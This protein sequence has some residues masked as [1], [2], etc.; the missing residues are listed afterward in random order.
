[1]RWRQFVSGI[2]RE[3]I[4]RDDWPTEAIVESMAYAHYEPLLCAVHIKLY[5][6][7]IHGVRLPGVESERAER[8]LRSAEAHDDLIKL[9]SIG[10]EP[11]TEDFVPLDQFVASFLKSLGV[12]VS[13]K[14][15]NERVAP[16]A[17]S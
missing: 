17:A 12:Q 4:V 8:V 7:L 10:N 5:G 2:Q 14:V 6:C 13:I 1:V 11:R 15:V 16:A 3:Q 9:G